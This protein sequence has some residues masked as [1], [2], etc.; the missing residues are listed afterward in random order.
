M[1]R[2]ASCSGLSTNSAA[3]AESTIEAG[4][5][6]PGIGITESPS[7]SSHASAIICGLTPSSA[8][9]AASESIEPR[10]RA[11]VSQTLEDGLFKGPYLGA[12]R[13]DLRWQ[14]RVPEPGC[15]EHRI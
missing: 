6:A 14:I 11:G 4:R 2:R 12:D 5:E 3:S 10:A 1:L 7:E 9:T 13:S 8:P 15:R